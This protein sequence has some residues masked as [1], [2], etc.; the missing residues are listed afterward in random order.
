MN[1]ASPTSP[2]SS[3]LLLNRVDLPADRDERH[4]D[5]E[6]R[7]EH[8]AEEEDEVAV[9]KRRVAGAASARSRSTP[10]RLPVAG[11]LGRRQELDLEPLD[12]RALDVEHREAQ[13]VGSD[14]VAGLRGPADQVEHVAGDGVVVLVLERRAELLVEVVDRE[15]A[16]DP[17]RRLVDPLDRLVRQ[18]ELVL[19]LA[20]DLLEQVLE[21]D[22]ALRRAVLVDDDRH[23]LVR[24]PELG[25]Q[26]GQVLRLGH[27]VGGPQQ[28]GELDLGDGAVVER[29]DEVAHVQDADDLVER[30]AE[31]RVARVR[32]VE[33]GRE[34]LLGRHLD[35]DRRRPRDAAPSRPTPPCRR[36][37]RPCRASRARPARSRRAAVETSSSIFSSASEWASPS[38]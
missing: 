4:L 6:A 32:R 1:I 30:L 34:R 10:P 23:V 15:R 2:R 35:R 22:D 31:D 37:R 36:S 3:G 25:E 7:R 27:D 17:D 19:D 8:D 29:R 14:L 20:D 13:A 38:V 18:V 16:V 21:R 11:R 5:R 28:R 26:R 12:P 24:A 9:P 33:H